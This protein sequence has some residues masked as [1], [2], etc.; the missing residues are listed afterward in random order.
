MDVWTP[1]SWTDLGVHSTFLFPQS[2]FV[3]V[4]LL[5]KEINKWLELREFQVNRILAES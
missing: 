5:P 3:F 4:F 2:L 1:L